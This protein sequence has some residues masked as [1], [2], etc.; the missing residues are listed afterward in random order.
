MQGPG[1]RP[2]QRVIFIFTQSDA[3][4]A[5]V[6]AQDFIGQFNA[7]M[8]EWELDGEL[9]PVD[10]IVSADAYDDL[11]LKLAYHPAIRKAGD[12]PPLLIT[13]GDH[14]SAEVCRYRV[15]YGKTN[16]PQLFCITGDPCKL[17]LI[18]MDDQLVANTNG[19]CAIDAQT[20]KKQLRTLRSL[21][22]SVTSIGVLSGMNCRSDLV[23][24]QKEET[25]TKW[26]KAAEGLN[27]KVSRVHLFEEMDVEAHLLTMIGQHQAFILLKDDT[28]F[29]FAEKIGK[30]CDTHGI[31]LLASDLSLVAH[32][33]ALGYGNAAGDFVAPLIDLMAQWFEHNLPLNA[34]ELAL[35]QE[36][37]QMWHNIEHVRLQVPHLS[38]EVEDM[39]EMYPIHLR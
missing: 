2:K 21:N 26:R 23:A 17:D 33:A 27:M 14:A 4:A 37:T 28:V 30:F 7:H 6:W 11:Q 12:N 24:V 34:F 18:T 39:L 10:Y 35:L 32:G 15:L 19:V 3:Q 9:P 36:P 16:I 1:I 20:V 38:P 13:I 25:L 8:R 29:S 5:N 31:T 22:R